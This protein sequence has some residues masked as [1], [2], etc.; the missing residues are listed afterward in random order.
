M[1]LFMKWTIALIIFRKK[2]SIVDVRLAS[3]YASVVIL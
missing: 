1:E 2:G 3:K